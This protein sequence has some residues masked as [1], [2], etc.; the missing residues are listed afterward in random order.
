MGSSG[1]LQIG[2]I[3]KKKESLNKTGGIN[4]DKSIFETGDNY[5][6]HTDQGTYMT[7]TEQLAN[8]GPLQGSRYQVTNRNDISLPEVKKESSKQKGRGAAEDTKVSSRTKSNVL[9]AQPDLKEF[10][11]EAVQKGV[12]TPRAKEA[13]RHFFKQV[14]DWAGTFEDGGSG[15]YREM[16][17]NN[18]LDC[19]YVDGMSFRNFVRDQYLHKATGN[20]AHQQETLRNYLALIAARG[21]HVITLVRPSLKG[22]GAEVEYKNL[23]V[24]LQNVGS[25]EASQA[26]KLREKGDQVRNELKKRIDSEMTER[27][28]IAYRKVNGIKMDGFMR[29]EEA[30]DRIKAASEESSEEYKTFKESFDKYNGGLQKLGL[31]PGRDDISF[32]VAKELKKRC[33]SALKAADAY[34]RK[35]AGSEETV[36]AVKQAKKQLETDS[37]LLEHA[38]KTRLNDEKARIRLCDL[39]D[40][41]SGVREEGRDDA[42]GEDISGDSGPAGDTGGEG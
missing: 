33:D 11:S 37:V 35:G 12:F 30:S 4:T 23:F 27:T 15:F 17:V 16:G 38:I 20:P 13:A 14:S 10:R 2:D 36:K 39:T 42:G 25:A 9:K 1:N 7:R 28:G 34:I 40:S 41:R 29:I 32:N 21:N 31:V 19:L 22:K 6:S 3:K 8:Y 5:G 24:D 18:V 26:K